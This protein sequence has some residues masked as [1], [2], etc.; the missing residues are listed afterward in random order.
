M[1]NSEVVKTVVKGYR[2]S[3]PR[4]CPME[5][6]D[7]MT[8]CWK[9]KPEDRPSTL[10]W[11]CG[12]S[13]YF[14]AFDQ[15]FDELLALWKKVNGITSNYIDM[16]SLKAEAKEVPTDDYTL[17]ELR[18]SSTRKESNAGLSGVYDQAPL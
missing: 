7:M 9:E 13:N 15:L 3:L 5:I 14:E 17:S 18:V 11:S 4:D 12:F 8:R 2:M 10:R 16:S 6:Y 1:S